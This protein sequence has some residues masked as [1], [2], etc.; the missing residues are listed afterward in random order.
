MPNFRVSDV[1]CVQYEISISINAPRE[2][3]WKGLTEQLSS[4]WLPDFH[5]LGPDSVVQLEPRAGGRLFEQNSA[6]ELLWYT[7]LSIT[8]NETLN[9]V[10]YCTAE[11]GG[12]STTM[13]TVRLVSDGP[14]TQVTIAD[15]L[16]G[17][18]SDGHASSLSAGWA[19][20]FRDGLKKFVE[21]SMT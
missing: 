16:F 7:V 6:S 11:F 1:R 9:L 2:R 21:L 10:G 4:W 17:V 15:S 18:V 14:S 19:Q 13:L 5:M 3:V 12:P 8:P 20:L